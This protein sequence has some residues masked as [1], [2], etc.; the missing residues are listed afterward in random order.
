LH[1][2]QLLA[3]KIPGAKASTNIHNTTKHVSKLEI[4]PLPDMAEV[5]GIVTGVL[6]LLPLCRGKFSNFAS[7]ASYDTRLRDP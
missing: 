5:F 6:G 7:D 1:A 4:T 2:N 3:G